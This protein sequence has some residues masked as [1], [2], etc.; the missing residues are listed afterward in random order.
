MFY[1]NYT[2]KDYYA[3]LAD[4]AKAVGASVSEDNR[5]DFPTSFAD[6][7]NKVI[8]LPNGLQ[9]YIISVTLNQDFC[10]TRTKSPDEF[11]ALRFDEIKIADKLTVKFGREELSSS[12]WQSRSA[13]LLTSS[14]LDFGFAL[15]KGS[16]IKSINVLITKEWLAKY[17]GIDSNDNVIQKY[18]SLKTASLNFEPFDTE[19]RFLLNEVLEADRNNKPL[20]SVII[21]NRIMLLIERFFTRLYE[22]IDPKN[23]RSSLD[24]ETIQQLMN[25]ESAL[26]RDFSV[27]PPTIAQLAR[28]AAMSE[29]KLKT[30]FKKIYGLSIYEYYQKNRMLKANSLLVTRK[31][32]V[33]EVGLML[34][35]KNLSNFTIAFKKEFN[36]LPSDI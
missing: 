13:V 26:V 9:A 1:L 30:L 27:A 6:G 33:K 32:S 34:N 35:F 22:K 23:F 21:Q 15:S 10:I 12:V 29:T 24:D 20:K 7:Y 17:L 31:Y 4:L 5:L 3:F 25:V 19:Y 14:L 36:I 16:A 18:L 8:T 2:H 28:Q 11:Y